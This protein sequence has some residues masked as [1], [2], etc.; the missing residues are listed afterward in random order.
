MNGHFV[1]Y[2]LEIILFSEKRHDWNDVQIYFFIYMWHSFYDMLLIV[3][4]FTK[5]KL[6]SKIIKHKGCKF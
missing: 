6:E 5:L 2:F 1:C 3:K 4:L